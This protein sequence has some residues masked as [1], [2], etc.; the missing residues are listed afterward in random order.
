MFIE[1]FKIWSMLLAMSV[2][3][4]HGGNITRRFG[5]NM[6]K[7]AF[8]LQYCSLLKNHKCDH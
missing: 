6:G 7:K 3:L 8:L 4:W 2:G 1:I 5:W